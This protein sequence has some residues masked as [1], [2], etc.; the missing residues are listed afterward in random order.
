MFGM[1]LAQ[2]NF[3]TTLSWF[4]AMVPQ[5]LNIGAIHTRNGDTESCRCLLGKAY[6]LAKFF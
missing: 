6:E 3:R 5:F 4:Y 2:L 1:T